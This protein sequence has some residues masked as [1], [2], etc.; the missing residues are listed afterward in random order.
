MFKP[1]L[2]FLHSADLHLD[3]PFKGLSHL[4]EPIYKDVLN[5]TIVAFKRLID[6]AIK[7]NVD[8][9]LI[10]GDLFDQESSSIKSSLELKKD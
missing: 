2:R 4:P 7:E 5:S 6:L 3:S 1:N 9:V 10:V 8:F